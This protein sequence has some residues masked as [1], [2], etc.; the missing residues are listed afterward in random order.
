ME[1]PNPTPETFTNPAAQEK[2]RSILDK[3]GR[4]NRTT[5]ISPTISLENLY[6][7]LDGA[8]AGLVR[9]LLTLDPLML[10]FRGPFVSM[11]EVPNNLVGIEGQQYTH[12]GEVITI[13][14]QYLPEPAWEAFQGMAAAIH[15]DM[16]SLLMVESG[17]RSPAAQAVTFLTF[18]E[19]NSFDIRQT[20]KGVALPGYS[21]HGDPRRT[22]VDVINQDGVPD[23]D[24]PE[25]FEHTQEYYWLRQHAGEHHFHLSYPNADNDGIKF[26]PWHWQYRG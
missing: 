18:L 14:K 17:Y 1:L 6:A 3:T 13:R 22:A 21:Q 4:E 2:I 19:M 9:Q 12:Q 15:R 26:E 24:R 20:A 23:D 5:K 16:G 25:E 7:K 10:G 11:E 8:E